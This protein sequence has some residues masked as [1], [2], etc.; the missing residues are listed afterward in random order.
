M[1]GEA[2]ARATG[3]GRDDRCPAGPA[4]IPAAAERGSEASIA[5]GSATGRGAGAPAIS[6]ATL[7]TQA[8]SI[9]D[10][11][12]L[13]RAHLPRGIFEYVARGTDEDRA[14]TGNAA[15]FDEIQ[16]VPRV[17][18]DVSKVTTACTLFGRPS[19]AP[20]AIAPTGFGG[21]LWLDGEIAQARAAAAAGIPFALSA[22]SITPMERIKAEAGGRLWLQ[23]YVWPQRDMTGELIGRARRAG[24]EALIVTVDTPVAPFRPHN[25]RNGFSI[26]FKVTPRNAVDIALHPRWLFNVVFRRWLRSGPM[27]AENYPEALRV[28]LK[29]AQVGKFNLPFCDDPTWDE[30]AAFRRLWD[31]PFIVKGIM[32]PEDAERAVAAGADGIVVS[33]HGGRNLDV[34]I[35]SARVLPEIADRVGARATVLLDSGIMRGSD[36]AKAIALGAHGVLAGKAPLFGVGAAGEAGVLRA[37]EILTGELTRVMTNAGARELADLR[38]E[39]L[40]MPWDFARLGGSVRPA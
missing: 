18:R 20:L 16:I 29:A 40:R 33:N 22:G 14:L 25:L 8:L 13:A 23:L 30:I 38:R 35:A 27:V 28:P 12:A 2:T 34:A 9:D 7:R 39:M 37:I 32:H 24:Y 11:K 19:T 5:P 26:P 10:L 1:Q 17:V 21:L 6:T 36:I 4:P 31:G 3:E 15:A